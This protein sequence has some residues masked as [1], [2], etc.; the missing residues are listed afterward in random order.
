MTPAGWLIM[1]LSVGSVS[2][3]LTWCIFKV[4]TTPEETDHIHGFEQETP[5][6]Q[7]TES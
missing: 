3:L 6:S 7:Q 5:D 4:L 2:I 1:I